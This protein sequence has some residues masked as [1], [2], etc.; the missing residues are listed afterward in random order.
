MNDVQISLFGQFEISCGEESLHSL[1]GAKGT[2]LLIYLFLHPSQAQTRDH[3]STLLWSEGYTTRRAKTYLRKTLWGLQN[4]LEACPWLTDLSLLTVDAEWV[5]LEIPP[6]AWF[7]LALFEEAYAVVKG[8][9]GD[10]LEPE[11]V[12]RLEEAVDLY[13]GDLL[14]NWYQRWCLR[15]RN[16]IQRNYV[17]MLDKL[18]AYSRAHGWYEKGLE[19][20]ER[21]LRIDRA[22]EQTHRQLMHLRHLAGDRTGALRQ[23]EEC[24]QALEEELDITPSRETQVLYDRIRSGDRELHPAE[25]PPL[26][27]AGN[28]D[29]SLEEHLQRVRHIRRMLGTLQGEIQDEIEAIDRLFSDEP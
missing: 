4:D 24:S 2:E 21:I 25:S 22:R 15:E 9:S 10:V 18:L 26:S 12:V 16:R 5:R 1:G 27:P 11:H 23:Y 29:S 17:L 19:Y 6:N 8:K 7:D 20:G 13:A 3:L 14:K 28:D